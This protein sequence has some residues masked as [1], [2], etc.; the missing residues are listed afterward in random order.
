LIAYEL[1][2]A[3]YLNI[4]NRCTNDCDFCIRRTADGI[5][6]HR[7]WLDEEPGPEE[8]LRAVGDP[9]GYEEVVFC[10][11]GEPLLRLDVVVEVSRAIKERG[12]RVRVDTNGHANLVYGRN[13]V[14]DFAR[15]VDEVSVSL[16]AQDAA[17]YEKICHTVYGRRA[18]SAVL[19]FAREC[20]RRVGPVTL[21][22][23]EWEGVDVDA[24]EEI[25]RRIGARLRV[26]K[27]SRG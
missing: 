26:R 7:L 14:P 18:F 4:T 11:Y 22:V 9:T 6:G 16:N 2:E 23:V 20:V 1:G 17:T 8:V 13:V 10:G 15:Y 3:L 5:G 19:E 21:T 24:C 27:Y 25:A 12:G